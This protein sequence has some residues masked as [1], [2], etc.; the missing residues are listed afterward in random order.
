MF[1]FSSPTK[2]DLSKAADLQKKR[3]LREKLSELLSIK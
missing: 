2:K 3:E 1:D